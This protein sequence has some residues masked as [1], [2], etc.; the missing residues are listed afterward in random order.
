MPLDEREIVAKY[1]RLKKRYALTEGR[2]MD[3]R[4]ARHGNL[5]QVFPDLVSDNWPKSIV[6]NFVDTVARDLSEITAPLPSFNCSSATMR[7]DAARRFADKRSKIANNYMIHSRMDVQMLTG[8][9]HYYSYGLTVFYIEPDFEAK[10]PRITV[11]DPIGGYAEYDR[12]GRINSY[13]KR[14][15]GEAEVLAELWPEHRD[16]ITKAAKDRGSSGSL[17][18]IRYCDKDQ[19]TLVLNGAHPFVLA[20]VKNRLGRVP[21]VIA[22][23]AWLDIHDSKGQFDDVIWVQ[24][25]RDYMA[26]LQ[27][28]A[29]EKAVQAPLAL[30]SDIQEITSGPDAILRSATPEKIRRVALELSPAGFQQQQLMAEEMREGARYPGV[31][32]GNTNANIITGK[33]VQAL[34]GG[35][36]SQVKA[37]QSVYKQAFMDVLALCFQMDEAVWPGT[38]KNVRGQAAG[39]PFDFSYTPSKDIAGEHF[40]DVTYGFAT[41]MDP[42]RA[43]VMLLQ[44]R[45]EKAISR[46]NFMRQLPLDLNV[47]EETAKVDV[48]ETRDAI[49][50]GIFAYVQSIPAMVQ[51]GMDP[52]QAIERLTS[53]VE[54]LSKGQPIEKVVAAAFA[55]QLPAGAT[56]GTEPPGGGAPGQPGQPGQGQGQ[57]PPGLQ[58]GMTPSGLM[59]GVAPG[60]AGEAPG[61]RPDLNVM[62]AGLNGNGNPQMS[63]F[64]MRRRRV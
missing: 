6:A 25:A 41:G 12:W 22:R 29:V 31:R 7:S 16:R 62:L 10:L 56:P 40:V 13:L 4:S 63:A 33:G 32:G 9:D 11:E 8:A 61:G 48:E 45:A 49:K 44:L 64:T 34:L 27:L 15:Y 19:I 18:I 28:E 21:I 30:P 55:P 39:V 2:W 59:R 51:Q 50:Q 35:F 47:T 43:I 3:V 17:E 24:L 38:T 26:K 42:N 37:A 53:V 46:D 36:D 58:G 52:A 60:Q 20:G 14:W 23:K 5:E 54:G 57:G 1:Q